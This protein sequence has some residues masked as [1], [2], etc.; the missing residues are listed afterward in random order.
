MAYFVLF[1]YDLILS[2]RKSYFRLGLFDTLNKIVLK[3]F[4]YYFCLQYV[5]KYKFTFCLFD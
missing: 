4:Y 1:Y 3:N 5:L 2:T